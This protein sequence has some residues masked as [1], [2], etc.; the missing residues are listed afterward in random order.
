MLALVSKGLCSVVSVQCF[1]VFFLQ[2]RSDASNSALFSKLLALLPGAVTRAETRDVAP[3][4]GLGG[5]LAFGMTVI[6][7]TREQ[8]CGSQRP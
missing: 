8:H 1:F 3:A 5:S 4:A 7:A 2:H 6:K